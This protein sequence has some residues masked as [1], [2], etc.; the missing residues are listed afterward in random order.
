MGNIPQFKVV[1]GNT[2]PQ[3]PIEPHTDGEHPAVIVRDIA[4]RPKPRGHVIV[5]AN[6]K[7]GVGKSTLAFH[8]C[9]A[10]GDSGY[11]VAA[12]DLDRRQQTLARGLAH[13]SGTARRLGVA[14]P[15]P[16]YVVLQ[17]PTG[18]MLHQEIARM[19]WDCDYVVIDAPGFDC[20]IGRRAIA[21]AETLVT[22]VNSSFVDL[23]LLGQFDP[24]TLRYRENGYFTRLVGDLSAERQR[25][26]LSP[27]DWVVAPNRVRRGSNRNQENFASALR[28][29]A[30]RAGFRVA[31]G[32][33]ERMVYRELALMGLTQLDLKRIPQF[34]N[35]RT[36][37]QHELVRLIADLDLPQRNDEPVLFEP[38]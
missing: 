33:S 34:A 22:P 4:S 23:E 3:I 18:A 21:M 25:Q 31:D 38:A 12:I 17:Q 2:A 37:S 14:L 32:L 30:P 26:G 5:L 8:L 10:L 15:T 1:G 16:S 36:V 9:V 20:P 11:R 13:R 6:E 27:I 35:A 28:R 19:G 7:G 24:V 29:L